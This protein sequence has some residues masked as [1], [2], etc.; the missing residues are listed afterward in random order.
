MQLLHNIETKK[1][2]CNPTFIFLFIKIMDTARYSAAVWIWIWIFKLQHC[3]SARTW[4][5]I[6]LKQIFFF[7]RNWEIIYLHR[8]HLNWPEAWPPP[9]ETSRGRP[10]PCCAGWRP[11][12]GPGPACRT[13]TQTCPS[14]VSW[15]AARLDTCQNWNGVALIFQQVSVL[16]SPYRS[17][18][19][20]RSYEALS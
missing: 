10:G 7:L 2:F 5:L 20:S 9:P 8:F 16:L 17:L 13:R 15:S 14:P 4:Y 1:I 18:H 12:P 19:I 3:R 6:G 11:S